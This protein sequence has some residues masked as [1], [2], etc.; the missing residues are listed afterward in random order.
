[1]P[2][3]IVVRH[4]VDNISPKVAYMTNDS[5]QA[6]IMKA[7]LNDA[8]QEIINMKKEIEAFV[9]QYEKRKPLFA[10]SEVLKNFRKDRS[11]DFANWLSTKVSPLAHKLYINAGEATYHV[12]T[13]ETDF[14]HW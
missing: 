6:E 10:S 11:I 12:E 14:I 7:R 3:Y 13:V 4:S 8:A 9:L 5:V 2:S 1:M